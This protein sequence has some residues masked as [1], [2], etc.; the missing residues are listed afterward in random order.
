[1]TICM[2][3]ESDSVGQF[4]ADIRRYPVWTPKEEQAAGGRL[5]KARKRGDARAI[6]AIE[7]D[8]VRHNL[9]LVVLSAG[10]FVGRGVP[11]LDLIQEG[12]IGLMRAAEK[13]DPT[14]GIRFSTYAVWWIR[15]AQ[16]RAIQNDGVVRVPVHC[17]ENA[18]RVGR[19]R[20]RIER[21]TGRAASSEEIEGIAPCPVEFRVVAATRWDPYATFV[22]DA[23]DAAA[24]RR[25]AMREGMWT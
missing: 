16:R 13:F 12:T 10:K 9:R 6:R 2:M 25:A 23:T 22:S 24:G 7:H 4:G 21:V 18:E 19:A 11:I 17:V 5:V 15:Q 8:F 14:R 3:A 20:G 1:M